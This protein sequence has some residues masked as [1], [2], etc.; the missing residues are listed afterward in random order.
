MTTTT[1]TKKILQL[2]QKKKK[3]TKSKEENS[4]NRLQLQLQQAQ[5]LS[6]QTQLQQLFQKYSKKYKKLYLAVLQAMERCGKDVINARKMF[7]I[8]SRSDLSVFASSEMLKADEF[9]STVQQSTESGISS[10]EL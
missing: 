8:I 10:D 7:V 3:F 6:Q 5:N 2:N 4:Q 1:N 9:I